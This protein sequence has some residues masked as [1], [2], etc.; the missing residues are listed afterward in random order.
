MDDKTLIN[1]QRKIDKI[2]EHDSDFR[3]NPRWQKLRRQQNS[4]YRLLAQD[5]VKQYESLCRVYNTQ[6]N[7]ILMQKFKDYLEA[8]NDN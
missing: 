7:K 2:E 5:K 3:D 1:L 8:N 6:E 4:A